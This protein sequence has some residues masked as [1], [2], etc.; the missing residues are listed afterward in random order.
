MGCLYSQS[1]VILVAVVEMV[2]LVMVSSVL[3]AKRVQKCT[4]KK[5]RS[6]ESLA[7]PESPPG[8]RISLYH[9]FF[10]IIL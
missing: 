2:L 6:T 4:P 3:V 8:I 1:A 5:G 7:E 9:L 10:I